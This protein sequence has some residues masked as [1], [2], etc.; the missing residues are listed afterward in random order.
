MLPSPKIVV[1]DDELEDVRAIVEGLNALGAAAAGVHFSGEKLPEFPC[2]RLLFLD[3]HLVSGTGGSQQQIK[4]TI[5]LLPD[6]LSSDHGPYVI[7]L[8]SG[9][10][11]ECDAF[12][13]AATKHLVEGGIPVP[14]S[15]VS[16]N[17]TEFIVHQEKSRQVSDPQRLQDTILQHIRENP[18]M[19]ALLGW[20]EHVS[21][22]ANDTIR[23]L[24]R[25]ARASEG[26]DLSFEINRVL[27]ELAV[28]SAG[29][30]NAQR[31]VF[32]ATNEVLSQFIIDRLMHRGARLDT[33]NVWR[34]AVTGLQEES[35]LSDVDTARLNTF[36]HIETGDLLE[37]VKP[38]DRG[39][40]VEL[41]QSW[42][43]GFAN[44]W[45]YTQDA[46]QEEF[47]LPVSENP[48]E[49]DATNQ[50][51][52]RWVMVQLQASCDHAQGNRSLLP[53]VLG[54][55]HV[56]TAGW[57]KKTMP[58]AV[59]ISPRIELKTTDGDVKT[60]C[61]VV[62]FRFVVG[63]PGADVG[64]LNVC[65]RLREPLLNQLTHELHSYGGRPGIIRFPR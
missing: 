45:G 55:L 24:S 4:S 39:S 21:R 62:H 56:P 65:C 30:G 43:E 9:H 8:W 61:L 34:Q 49:R 14:L 42:L 60:H 31:D 50:D 23:E 1:V 7:V 11:D 35:A 63:L 2:L 22:S 32:R 10:S 38:G 51:T 58:E 44:T 20:E 12:R 25:I 33:Q 6:L 54:L 29:F 28:A 3:L 40:V 64:K 17:K 5:G 13:A 41:P 59:W 48:K 57:L 26:G 36:L 46:L 15:I 47:K 37:T 18:Q 19:A 52:R 16:M 53:Y 27:G